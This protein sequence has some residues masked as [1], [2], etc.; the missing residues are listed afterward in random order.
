MI[1]VRELREHT[2]E[3]L[4]QVRQLQVEY[5]ITHQGRPVALL[6][7]LQAEAVEAAIVQ[8][9]QRMAVSGWERYAQ[10]AEQVRRNWPPDQ[11]TQD[12]LDEIR[13]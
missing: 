6:L 12:L 13:G 10:V 8:M 9:G 3:V 2:A 1:G 5:I 7:P 4:R 11:K